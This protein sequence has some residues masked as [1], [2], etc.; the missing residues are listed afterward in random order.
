MKNI[1]Y[2]LLFPFFIFSQNNN[3]SSKKLIFSLESGAAIYSGNKLFEHRKFSREGIFFSFN[4][5]TNKMI[6]K[7]TNMLSQVSFK[8]SNA[9]AK[10]IDV[11]VPETDIDFNTKIP[12]ILSGNF[13]YAIKINKQINNFLTHGT[14]LDFRI[15]SLFYKKGQ[16]FNAQLHSFGGFISSEDN[17]SLPDLEKSLQI[18]YQINCNLKN[19]MLIGISLFLNSDW[20]IHNFDFNPI[21][22]GL[23][24]KFEKIISQNFQPPWLKKFKT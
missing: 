21:Y 15:F 2:I 13:N 6:T 7:K 4:F 16:L 8:L 12:N 18:S 24:I 14:V 11:I 17:G 22:P 10:K 9:I 23:S 20:T 5:F 1:I 3:I 19:Q